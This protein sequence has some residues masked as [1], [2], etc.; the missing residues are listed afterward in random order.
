MQI[1]TRKYTPEEVLTVL[2]E[3]HRLCAELNMGDP[4]M[5]IS[6]DM[7]VVDW[8]D[9][10]DLKKW[11]GLY[12]YLNEGWKVDISK[13]EWQE[14]FEP[15]TEKK[16]IGLCSLI[17]KYADKVEFGPQN[18]MGQECLSAGLFLGIKNGLKI[19]GI[20]VNNLKPSSEIKPYLSEYPSEVLE[21]L[22]Q[23]G[24]SVV[25]KID[26]SKRKKTKTS[27]LQKLNIFDRY[28]HDI[29]FSNICTFRDFIEKMIE[30]EK[31]HNKTYNT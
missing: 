7:L 3:Q 16:L 31:E 8:R 6:G 13:K 26:L 17:A 4:D 18:I 1:K 28:H 12:E 20:D 21:E 27:L 9:A 10:S 22:T 15:Q 25:D 11:T 30:K 14:V 2:K 19:R 5:V 23:S 29:Y 24:I